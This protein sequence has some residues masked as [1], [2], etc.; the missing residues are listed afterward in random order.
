MAIRAKLRLFTV[1]LMMLAASP[2]VFAPLAQAADDNAPA[3][4][5]KEQIYEAGS[6]SVASLKRLSETAGRI[7]LELPPFLT[8]QGI[9]QQFSFIGA[10]GMDTDKPIGIV[11]YAGEKYEIEQGQGMVFVLPVKPDA[12]PLSFFKNAGAQPLGNDGNAVMLNGAAFRRTA[13]QLMFGPTPAATLAVPNDYLAKLYPQ[14]A[15]NGALPVLRLN[16]DFAAFRKADPERFSKLFQGPADAAPPADPAEKFG[17]DAAL[18]FFKQLTHINLT[19]LEAGNDLQLKLA[20]APITVP[21]PG[22]FARAAMPAEVFAR[23]DLAAA[24]AQCVSS[25]YSKIEEAINQFPAEK[26]EITPEKRQEAHKVFDVLKNVFADGAAASL[27]VAPQGDGFVVYLVQQQATPGL[28][29]RLQKLAD[30]LNAITQMSGDAAKG[31]HAAIEHYAA[32]DGQPV[33]RLVARQPS[34]PTLYVDGLEKNGNVYLAAGMDEGHHVL[35]LAAGQMGGEMKGL[36]SGRVNLKKVFELAAKSP[37]SPIAHFS[38]EQKGKI[39]KLFEHGSGLDFTASGDGDSIVFG[40][41]LPESLV[42][43]VVS[44]IQNGG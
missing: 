4:N 9:E 5:A 2:L 25:L 22:N 12:A 34:E 36:L 17:R 21:Q 35:D 15:A 37:D 3:A 40:V 14:A 23:I 27:G 28:E 7:G 30:E 33:I 13:D 16:I 6:G 20:V 26:G 43:E 39:E 29:G 8:A 32:D 10:G 11:Y 44:F 24:P 19:L 18:N 1:G 31:F 38:A 42:K 41:A